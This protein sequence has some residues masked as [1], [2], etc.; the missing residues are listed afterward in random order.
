MATYEEHMTKGELEALEHKSH[1]ATYEG[2]M[3]IYEEHMT[4]NELGVPKYAY[5]G[6]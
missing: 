5:P 3:T 4:R 1:M 2:H 6:L